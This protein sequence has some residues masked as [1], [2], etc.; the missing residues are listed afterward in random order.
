MLY[1]KTAS[2]EFKL[3]YVYGAA[4]GER[5]FM[6]CEQTRTNVERTFSSHA[7]LE[8]LL[9]AAVLALV[10]VMLVDWTVATAAARVGEVA[11]D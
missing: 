3:I 9:E 2:V 6:L 1:E 5:A 7:D 10:A 8:T 4:R 11:S